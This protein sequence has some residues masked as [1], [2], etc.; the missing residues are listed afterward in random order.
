MRSDEMHGPTKGNPPE[1]W[2]GPTVDSHGHAGGQAG[3]QARMVHALRERA[4]DVR[5]AVILGV[6]S[7][8]D[9][10]DDFPLWAQIALLAVDADEAPSTVGL[11][12]TFGCDAT[13]VS[14]SLRKALD[15][16]TEWADD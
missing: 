9:R 11:A 7:H 1:V 10:E 14:G 5:D 13:Y 8:V 15:L 16:A 4:E 12:E 6:L 2:A 3:P